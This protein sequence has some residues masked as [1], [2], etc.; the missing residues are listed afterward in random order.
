MSLKDK[1]LDY[2]CQ[3]IQRKELLDYL[4]KDFCFIHG[5]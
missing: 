5:A 4:R 3:D 1:L 2:V